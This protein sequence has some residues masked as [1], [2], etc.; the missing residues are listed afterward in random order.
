MCR[1]T[2]L[3]AEK[4]NQIC[5]GRLPGRRWT[6]MA[7]AA[8]LAHLPGC[9]ASQPDAWPFFTPDGAVTI[10]H[11]RWGTSEDFPGRHSLSE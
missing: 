4:P 10:P 9:D 11:M 8:R 2:S 1:S 7:G 6:W 3:T 5:F